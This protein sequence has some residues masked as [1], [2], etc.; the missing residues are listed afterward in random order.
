MKLAKFLLII[1]FCSIFS[2]AH[3]VNPGTNYGCLDHNKKF[4]THWTNTLSA[5]PTNAGWKSKFQTYDTLPDIYN[6]TYDAAT[7]GQVNP[8]VSLSEASVDGQNQ[9]F[10]FIGGSWVQG[11][12]RTFSNM[13]PCQVTPVPLDDFI[14]FIIV[15]IS[16]VGFYQLKRKGVL[17]S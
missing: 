6:V 12:L 11:G 3:A 16:V 14:P 17:A 7:C 13:P 4:Y 1:T 10:I 2:I 15:L 9:C 8:N 5:S